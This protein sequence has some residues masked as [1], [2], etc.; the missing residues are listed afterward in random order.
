MDKV[1]QPVLNGYCISTDSDDSG[2]NEFT[3]QATEK[4]LV[5]L[6]FSPF[7]PI[8]VP[9]PPKAGTILFDI[10]QVKQS[11][12]QA[13]TAA[14]QGKKKEA[15]GHYFEALH[16]LNFSHLD[17]KGLLVKML[18]LLQIC[19]FIRDNK[20]D[21]TNYITEALKS[22]EQL[23]EN[24]WRA[25]AKEKTDPIFMFSLGSV[26]LTMGR[27]GLNPTHYQKARNYLL[28]ALKLP[29]PPL[30]DSDILK[31]KI[32]LGLGVSYLYQVRREIIISGTQKKDR[33]NSLLHSSRD[34]LSQALELS[35]HPTVQYLQALNHGFTTL[36]LNEEYSCETKESNK[37]ALYEEAENHLAQALGILSPI[38]DKD[39]DM[40]ALYGCLKYQ[41]TF[42]QKD[43]D[44][45][46][47][48]DTF[49]ALSEALPHLESDAAIP[50]A[51]GDAARQ[52]AWVFPK[53]IFQCQA[54]QYLNAAVHMDNADNPLSMSNLLVFNIQRAFW[55]IS[56]TNQKLLDSKKPAP[57]LQEMN[58]EDLSKKSIECD[59][60]LRRR[61]ILQALRKQSSLER[62]ENCLQN[63]RRLEGLKEKILEDLSIAQA[64]KKKGP[65]DLVYD[66]FISS[67]KKDLLI[68]EILRETALL[69][70]R[71]KTI[72]ELKT[73][74][75]QLRAL[76]ER[77]SD[78]SYFTLLKHRIRVCIE[79]L[80]TDLHLFSPLCDSQEKLRKFNKFALKMGDKLDSLF[81]QTLYKY[82]MMERLRN[83]DL[84]LDLEI[85]VV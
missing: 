48:W 42:D 82:M 46:G 37:E 8:P 73:H 61:A 59:A 3:I 18:C 85:P 40:L 43:I 75:E 26:Y 62:R 21:D 68:F 78:D 51:I 76:A 34:Y 17:S 6:K 28:G 20:G 66:S 9:P 57:P 53:E 70:L 84:V 16:H 1:V 77:R 49:K 25:D 31:H 64:H 32:L 47:A 22:L 14:S 58:L 81:V 33:L 69:D 45:E 83:L 36:L 79:P 27:Y 13:E 55:L 74:A 38:P 19:K 50:I 41:N 30:Q 2:D 10:V 72:D 44:Y 7:G 35:T 39:E 67:F 65:S 29:P 60:A 12:N 24:L 11:M 56:E 71:A 15:F 23:E 5:Y 52:L 63:L 54:E 80:I 4:G